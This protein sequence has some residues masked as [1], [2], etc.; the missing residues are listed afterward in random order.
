MSSNFFSL[1]IVAPKST[2]DC[3]NLLPPTGNFHQRH[4]LDKKQI[5]SGDY[6]YLLRHTSL[7]LR[8]DLDLID[9][10]EMLTFISLKERLFSDGSSNLK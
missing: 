2:Q 4:C 10:F 9:V 1:G 3:V 7:D 8:D 5:N 6:R